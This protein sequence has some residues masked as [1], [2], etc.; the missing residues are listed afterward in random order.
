MKRFIIILAFL[1]G[2]ASNSYAGAGSA[3]ALGGS[4]SSGS[5]VTNG[6]SHDHSGGDGAQIDHGGLG[7][8]TDDDHTGYLKEADYDAQTILHATS[9]N[10]PVALTVGEQTIVGRITGGNITALSVDQLRALIN[11]GLT[12]STKTDNYSLLSTDFG[13]S[14]RL[15]HADSKTLTLPVGE[16][17]FDGKGYFL[18]KQG[19][20]NMVVATSGGNTIG[21]GS[22]TSLTFTSQYQLVRV[23][24]CHAVTKW[25]L[26]TNGDYIT[27]P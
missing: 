1:L 25:L 7:G 16:A 11:S 13:F 15:N 3:I 12:V 26:D 22:D 23:E 14:I 2:I 20:G 4:D 9:D 21:P 27:T 19:A 8:L 24:Y 6:D 10:T 5:G 18:Y 17:A